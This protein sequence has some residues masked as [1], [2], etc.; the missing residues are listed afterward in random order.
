MDELRAVSVEEE[1]ATAKAG[2]NQLRAAS[3]ELRVKQ[4]QRQEFKYEFRVA[5]FELRVRA[6]AIGFRHGAVEK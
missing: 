1:Q 6:N 5:G 4:Q 2:L 3:L